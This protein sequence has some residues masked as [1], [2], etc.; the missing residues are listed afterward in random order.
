MS[1]LLGDRGTVEKPS[2]ED[3]FLGVI[4][5]VIEKFGE[6]AKISQPNIQK[7]IIGVLE[8][9]KGIY[10][11][12]TTSPVEIIFD[13]SDVYNGLQRIFD[14]TYNQ[15]CERFLSS[16]DIIFPSNLAEINLPE[17][18]QVKIPT[19][20]KFQHDNHMSVE[21]ADAIYMELSKEAKLGVAEDFK[22]GKKEKPIVS[23][24]IIDYPEMR[25]EGLAIRNEL[26]PLIET[27][28]VNLASADIDDGTK[29]KNARE[30]LAYLDEL[31]QRPGREQLA[32][33]Y[34]CMI[35][36]ANYQKIKGLA[37]VAVDNT[38]REILE[39]Q[40]ILFAKKLD[41]YEIC[42]SFAWK[43]LSKTACKKK[44]RRKPEG[45]KKIKSNYEG[46]Q[47]PAVPELIL[48]IGDDVGSNGE[49]FPWMDKAEKVPVL[50]IERGDNGVTVVVDGRTKAV[51]KI[52]YKMTGYETEKKRQEILP[53]LYSKLELAAKIISTSDSR[54]D[55]IWP[56]LR[57]RDKEKYPF[58]IIAWKPKESDAKRLYVAY[59]SVDGLPDGGLKN[60]LK[61]GSVS[62]VVI[63]LGICDKNNQAEL[64]QLFTG[65]TRERVVA[66][67]AGK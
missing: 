52:E 49:I 20:K 47:L 13:E 1:E 65:Q 14:D 26:F 28:V 66:E 64:L 36:D 51:K 38:A 63:L 56:P 31:P 54:L 39:S 40:V 23:D 7:K 29:L 43:A 44:S 32:N 59:V 17:Y 10:L 48:N 41:T 4:N 58:N 30:I 12:K 67:G 19:V 27:F 37:E 22:L 62:H 42:E 2:N 3:P 46:G 35:I 11:N 61:S 8:T 6:F 34:A 55:N 45:P 5:Y 25:D 57:N 15:A 60:E 9:A 21:V 24:F 50:H 53:S 18:C 16:L 33:E